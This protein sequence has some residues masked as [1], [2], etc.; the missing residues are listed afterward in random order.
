MHILLQFQD[1]QKET[2]SEISIINWWN[3]KYKHDLLKLQDIIIRIK[4]DKQK[5]KGIEIE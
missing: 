4:P 2:N 5:L 3:T 1:Y